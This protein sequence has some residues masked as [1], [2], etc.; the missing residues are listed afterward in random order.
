MGTT[1]VVLYQYNGCLL[2]LE[3][4]PM[5]EFVDLRHLLRDLL[6]EVIPVVLECVSFDKVVAANQKDTRGLNLRL[7]VLHGRQHLI[8][9]KQV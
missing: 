2:R 6:H 1:R 5:H 7:L 9:L 4:R 8:V 3:V